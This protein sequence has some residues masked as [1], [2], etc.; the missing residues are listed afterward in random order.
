MSDVR[1]SEV[2]RSGTGQE[3]E[4][5]KKEVKVR[6][7]GIIRARRNLERGGDREGSGVS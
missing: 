2:T 3:L 1:V 5:W 7:P 4:C 6:L